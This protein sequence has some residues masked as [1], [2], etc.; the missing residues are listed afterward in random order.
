MHFPAACG[1]TSNDASPPRSYRWKNNAF[2]MLLDQLKESRIP[3]FTDAVFML[4]ELASESADELGGLIES[5]KQKT[6]RDGKRHSFSFTLGNGNEQGISFVCMPHAKMLFQ[7]VV[8]L[9]VLKK[10][11]V[12][13]NEWLSLGSI[14]GS[15]KLIDVATFMKE[16][17]EPDPKLDAASRRLKPKRVMRG[18]QTVDR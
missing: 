11:Q 3:G 6:A 1:H 9:G 5:T 7:D 2:R 10:Y 17:W 13:A 12:R 16:P 8:A 14:S 4:Y 15:T 18:N